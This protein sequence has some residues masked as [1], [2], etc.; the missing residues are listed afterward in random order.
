MFQHNLKVIFRRLGRQRIFTA[1]H[2][3]GLTVSIACC[4]LIYLF[5]RHETGFDKYHKL[6]DRTY[7][8]TTQS[9]R[10]GEINYSIN[11]PYPMGEAFRPDF[12]D[13][14]KIASI[15]VQNSATV[16]TPDNQIRRI[17][18]GLYAEPEILDIFD[19]KL[20]T[21]NAREALEKPDH[22]LLSTSTAQ[23]L[24]ADADPMGKMIRLND[25]VAYKVAGL[26]ED[27][28]ANTHLPA[29]YIVSY[30]S[31]SNE[32]VG[33]DI[34]SW[35]VT[36]TGAIYV[37]LPEKMTPEQYEARFVAFANKY[38]RDED[39]DTVNQL[40]LQALE[41]IH[42]DTRYES[43]TSVNPVS[44]TYLWV[45]GSIG[46]LILLMACFNF[47]NLSLAQSIRKSTETGIRKV[48]GAER[49][50]LWI[51]N[52]G[53]AVILTTGAFIIALIAA[54][55]ALGKLNKTLN[56]QISW[57]DS[58]VLEFG[59]FSIG[60]ILLMSLLAG[61]YPAW[62]QASQNPVSI[63]KS[64][65][66]IGN[67]PNNR[68]QQF[69]VLAQ[70][71][72]TLV[73]I[74]SAIIV[75]KQLNHMQNL[76]LGFNQEAIVQ[77]PLGDAGLYESF[78]AE[79]LEIQGVEGVSFELGAPT[80]NSNISTSFYPYG[81]D[82]QTNSKR[83]GLK[84]VD[85][86]YMDLYQFEL[87]AGRFINALDA[88]S[89]EGDFPR[90]GQQ[91][92]VV[93]NEKL[94]NNIGIQKA[95]EAL[96]QRLILG[97]NNVEAT[98]VGVAEN[99]HTS[100]LHDEVRPTLMMPLPA[101]YY[102]IGVKIGA[103]NTTKTLAAV[104]KAYKNLFPKSIFEYTFLDE[105]VAEQ[106]VTEKRLFSLLQTF[107]SLAI[108]IACLGLFGLAVLASIHRRKEISLRKILGASVANIF[109][110]LSKDTLRLILIAVLIA[111]PL[112]WWL[113][114]RWLNNF[115][116]RIDIP[117]WVFVFAGSILLLISILT[118]SGQAL[119]AAFAN[120][121]DSLKQE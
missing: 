46:L 109:S 29:E 63:L 93:V 74:S 89:I 66:V 119:K 6:S 57:S 62:I 24:F 45:F 90:S 21:P 114:H 30:V 73:I 107:S 100:S 98:I 44:S 51:Q 59:L 49:K 38:M 110:L 85:P 40:G 36:I 31:L 61:A 68:L 102:E 72:I 71:I 77:I 3:I 35:G 83:M 1:I 23:N 113:M 82:P 88:K 10:E 65:K 13:L 58:S 105:T 16:Q 5:I 17:E 39:D 32:I 118:I 101:L 34:S 97:V 103:G 106:Y 87:K 2:L 80:S 8:I 7:R 41:D 116:Y 75:Y 33:F 120:P 53:E 104:E 117:W 52:I 121:A 70:F 76:D 55:L 69:T 56:N 9:E 91:C 108:F 27:T 67:R 94:I 14:E 26:F 92:N 12:Q 54:N 28:P 60:I 96:G 78:K 15:H 19:F 81:K 47:L 50:Q 84:P 4:I 18:N 43:D 111:T 115:A 48:L 22:I 99:F 79:L 42:F 11:S 112:S 25:T 64:S 95:T 20:L 37:V 86:D